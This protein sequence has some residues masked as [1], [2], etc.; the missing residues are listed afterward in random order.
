MA[1]GVWGALAGIGGTVGVVAR[2]GARRSLGWEWIFFVNVPVAVV[3]VVATPLV[4]GESARAK[5][6][7]RFDWP[8][9]CWQRSGY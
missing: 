8:A 2:R 7:R 1:L 4:V 5:A 9:R 6:V 3:A